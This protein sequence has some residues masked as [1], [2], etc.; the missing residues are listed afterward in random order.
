MVKTYRREPEEFVKEWYGKSAEFEWRR[1]QRNPYHRIEHMVTMHFLKKYLPRR[2]LILD[3]GGGPGRYSIELARQGYSVVLLDLVPEMLEIARRKA[4]RAGVKR[5]IKDFLQGSIDNLSRFQDGSFDAV[6]CLGAPL[7]HLLSQEQR[8]TAARELVR[9][10]KKRG[11]IFV[12]VISRLGLLRSILTRFPQEM[13]YAKHHWMVGD[14]IPGL[15]GQGF[16]AAH[17]FLPEELRGLFEKQDAKILELAGLEGLSSHHE[18]ETNSLY[19][20]RER[21]QM[22][23]EIILETCTHPSA[24]GSAEHFLLVAR[25]KG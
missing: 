9:V 22:W 15:H 5:N 18:K 17:W 14:Y 6:I 1:L 10:T 11:P 16:T 23:M 20:D 2:G 8:E 12:S 13:H 24:V 21:W 3:A 7:N 25:K 4:K 19:R